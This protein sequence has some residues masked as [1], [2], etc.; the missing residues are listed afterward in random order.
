MRIK[1]TKRLLD[2]VK[3]GGVFRPQGIVGNRYM[4]T[5]RERNGSA[6]VVDLST[7]QLINMY[8]SITVV[9]ID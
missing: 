7:G 5:D 6:T 3:P 2:N 1:E 9:E 8:T 4:K